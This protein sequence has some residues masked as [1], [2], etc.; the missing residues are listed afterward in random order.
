MWFTILAQGLDFPGDAISEASG[1]CL[2][3][4]LYSSSSSGTDL[5]NRDA[6]VERNQQK[7]ATAGLYLSSSWTALTVPGMIS[8]VHLMK[9]FHGRS[10]LREKI[11]TLDG[12]AEYHGGFRVLHLVPG[13]EATDPRDYVYGMLALTRLNIQPDYS[14]S[15]SEVL[16]DYVTASIEIGRRLSLSYLLF[17]RYAGIGLFKDTLGIPS[18]APNYPEIA[19]SGSPLLYVNAAVAN[20]GVFDKDVRDAV[21]SKR[22]LLVNGIRLQ[23]VVSSRG[24]FAESDGIRGFYKFFVSRRP[25]Y[26]TGIPSAQAVFRTLFRQ[27]NYKL[28]RETLAFSLDICTEFLNAIQRH[29]R[30]E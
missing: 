5:C 8:W 23:H 26:V 1:L 10:M 22:S 11:K 2:S 24:L 14:K 27:A 6:A 21:V 30:Q 4:C 17:L 13:F 25:Q 16:S 12:L 20:K 15:V 28:D 19:S 29:T 7:L 18:W 9:I 3:E